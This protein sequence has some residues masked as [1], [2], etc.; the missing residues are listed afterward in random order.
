MFLEVLDGMEVNQS[1]GGSQQATAK[2]DIKRA[3]Q[4]FDY[5]DVDENAIDLNDG[6]SIAS[7]IAE[8]L[9]KKFHNLIDANKQIIR[10]NSITNRE[11]RSSKEAKK[12]YDNG[13]TAYDDKLR[14]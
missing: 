9:D 7:V 6:R 14:R 3:A 11:W 10:I 1:T 2:Y 4:G 13:T 5:V 12:L 8:I